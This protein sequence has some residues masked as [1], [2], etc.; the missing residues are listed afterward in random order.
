MESEHHE[1]TQKQI[2][3]FWLPISV[4]WLM[5]AFEGPFLAAMIARLPAIEFNLAAFGIA[6]SIG[7]FVEAPI[8]MLISAALA[9]VRE[10]QSFVKLLVFTGVLNGAVTILMLFFSIPWVFRLFAIKFMGLPEELAHLAHVA[11]VLLIP[12]PAAIGFRRFYQGILIRGNRTTRVAYGTVVR[13]FSMLI[14]TLF[15]V[16]W[17]HLP[18]SWIGCTALS[19][20][21][22]VEAFV[23]WIMSWKII[24]ELKNNSRNPAKPLTYSK[25]WSFYY[26]LA[27]SS[28][29]ALGIRPVVSF[30]VAHCSNPIESLAVLPV[31]TSVSFLFV[32]FGLSFQEVALALL[33]TKIQQLYP[34]RKFAGWMIL[35]LS[36]GSIA[37]AF[38]FLS[39]LWF[40]GVSDLPPNLMSF[41][42]TP[43]RLAIILPA[44]AVAHSLQRAI[45]VN[46][47]NNQPISR[48]TGIEVCIIISIMI[49]FSY[50]IPVN[51][52][53]A[54]MVALI[55][56]Q[57]VSNAYLCTKCKFVIRNFPLA[58]S[59]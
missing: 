24:T 50:A 32:C 49:I 4:T 39:E 2:F 10:K 36:V 19:T 5:M 43:Y 44:L 48:A 7:L 16:R 31:V 6:F 52:V 8:T 3:K 42:I 23:T 37:T 40:S 57:I 51:G 14:T 45:L 13:L 33:G 9:L 35:I 58:A 41:A 30:F 59:R 28:M 53:I 54:A 46:A 56:G 12:W 25:I 22:T 11:T 29:M 1:L 21:V 26:P 55:F 38:S 47:K 20:G 17:T 15:L 34:I 27:M 18:G